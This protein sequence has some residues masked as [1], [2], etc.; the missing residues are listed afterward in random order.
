MESIADS[1]EAITNPDIYDI[2]RSILKHS[3]AVPGAVISKLLDSISSGFQAELDATI[4]DVDSGDHQAY[5]DHKTPLE[6]Y[7]FLLRFFVLA[8][9][10]V[11]ASD[12][13]DGVTAPAPK[14]RRGRGGKAAAGRTAAR[15]AAAKRTNESWTWIAQIPAALTLISKVLRLSSQRVWTITGERDNFIK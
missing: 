8:V 14:A 3:D 11:K 7:A 13:E 2:Y 9:E 15:G 12:E 4:R 6:M 5:L 1:S 10:K